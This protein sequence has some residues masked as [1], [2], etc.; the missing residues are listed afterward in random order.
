MKLSNSFFYT[1]RENVKDEDSAS[2]NLLVKG[3]Y[4]KKT[5]A[6]V[7]MYM[8]LGLRVFNKI[9][10]IIRE[11]MNNAGAIEMQM[12]SLIAAEYYEK[13]GRMQNF[14]SSV[15]TLNDRNNKKMV[16][17]P[18]HEELFA[19]AAKSMIKS[20]K[21]MPFNLYQFQNKFRDE[22]RARYGLIRV[23]EFCMK[24]A[25][26]FDVDEES[27][28][29]SYQKMFN[30]YVNT[31]NRLG[32]NYRIVKADTGMMG[33][34]LSEEFQ[35]I[36]PIGEDVVVYADECGYSSNLEIA[37]C[38]YLDEIKNTIGGKFEKVYTPNA[39]SIEEVCNYLNRDAKDFV[40]TLIYQL[41]NK[42]YAVMLRGDREV[43]ETKLQKLLKANEINL[44][45][46]ETVIKVTGAKVGFAGPINL[47]C[48]IV[49]DEEVL[50]MENYIVGANESD[51][52]LV[53][54]NNSDFTYEIHADIRQVCE[55]DLC[56]T[57]TNYRLK[58]AKGIEVGNTFK[59]GTKYSECLD[60]TYLDQNNKQNLVYMGSYGIGLGRCMAAIVEQNHDDNGIIW[61]TNIAPYTITLVQI[62]TK[63]EIQ[64][65]VAEDLYQELTSMGYDVLLDDRNERPGVKFNDMELIGI[66]YR[67][68]IGKR[69][70]ENIVE[71]KS[72]KT[73]EMLELNID[74]L[75]NKIN[76][77]IK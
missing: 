63:D 3:G 28:D 20:Y 41:D 27:L 31:F 52:H 72:R 1:L 64:N 15:Y 2:S 13:S 16:L 58:F 54:V 60:L 46:S 29:K 18:T 47:H 49:I 24:D 75:K 11:E 48:P 67:I 26:S 4:I 51:Y 35:A 12:P 22:P 7:Y 9:E 17:G 36:T 71:F 19:V 70:S 53:D 5:S 33:G 40:K 25:Y 76:D 39:G 21:N 50:R 8:P 42:V 37:E 65:K 62:S 45:D 30:A 38:V 73:G 14:G 77:L 59:L 68:T 10:N 6:G 69:A 61:P 56:P 57:N 44:A 23:K 55:G 34:M 43:S 74:E 66:P 32:L